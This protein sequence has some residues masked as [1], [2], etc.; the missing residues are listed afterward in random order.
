MGIQGFLFSFVFNYLLMK[1]DGYFITFGFRIELQ[2]FHLVELSDVLFICLQK[3]VCA[4][5]EVLK[6]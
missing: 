5:W 6:N 3:C 2:K 4:P 1:T